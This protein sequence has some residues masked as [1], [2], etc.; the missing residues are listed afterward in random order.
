M[1]EFSARRLREMTRSEIEVKLRDIEEELHNMKLRATLRQEAN[2][3]RMRELRRA[4]ARIKTMLR[5]DD[6]GIR[7]LAREE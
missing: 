7:R 6:L 3:V 4:I 1:R 2:P 5:E